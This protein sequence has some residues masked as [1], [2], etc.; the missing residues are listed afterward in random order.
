MVS[1]II[2]YHN[3][4]HRFS[5]ISSGVIS[6]NTPDV[7]A[8]L[9]WFTPMRWGGSALLLLLSSSS[10]LVDESDDDGVHAVYQNLL[11][12]GSFGAVCKAR[13]YMWMLSVVTA[14]Y[15]LIMFVVHKLH[16]PSLPEM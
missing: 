7:M 3:F 12:E 14:V 5:D 8:V 16:L 9:S 6:L 10:S 2:L 4:C 15:V 11:Q 13:S 1:L